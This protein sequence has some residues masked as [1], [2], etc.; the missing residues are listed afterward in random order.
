MMH[1]DYT[2]DAAKNLMSAEMIKRL[3]DSRRRLAQSLKLLE[4]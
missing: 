2:N 4:P 1:L 3:A